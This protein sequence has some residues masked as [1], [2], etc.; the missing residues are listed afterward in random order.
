MNVTTKLIG[1]VSPFLNTHEVSPMDDKKKTKGQLIAELDE[2]WKLNAELES[3][4]TDR[5]KAEK[6][7]R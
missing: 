4:E 1:V 7:L 5:K 2:L 6:A 3:E